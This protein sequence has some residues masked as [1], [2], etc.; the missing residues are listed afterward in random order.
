M[1]DSNV[2]R[3]RIWIEAAFTFPKLDGPFRKYDAILDN[4]SVGK[5]PNHCTAMIGCPG[6][7]PSTTFPLR[8]TN[9][10]STMT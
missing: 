8:T 5:R 7:T 3:C 2:G 6:V 9:V 10:P 1:S 4:G